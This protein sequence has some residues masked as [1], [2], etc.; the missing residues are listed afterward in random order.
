MPLPSQ[1]SAEIQQGVAAIT[2][3]DSRWHNCH[4]KAVTLLANVLLKQQASEAQAMEAILIRDGLAHEGTA[5]NLFIVNDGRLATP[6]IGP[7]LLSGITRDLVLE[8]ALAHGLPYQERPIEQAELT[9]A[10]EIW[11]T[12]STRE[13]IPVIQLDGQ[14]VGA[15]MPGR[16]W[17]RMNAWYQ[18]YKASLRRGEF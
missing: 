6:P 2:V 13:I 14:R 15:G 3:A 18:D 5:S 11:L 8:L 1:P 10:E 7:N 12:S 9:R 4:I 16:Q 17:Q